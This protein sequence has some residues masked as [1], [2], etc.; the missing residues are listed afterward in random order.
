MESASF[1]TYSS[2]VSFFCV[3][4]GLSGYMRGQ[5]TNEPWSSRIS[6]TTTTMEDENGSETIVSSGC[7]PYCNT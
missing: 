4:G 1:V 7:G 3:N 2:C 6:W 5:A